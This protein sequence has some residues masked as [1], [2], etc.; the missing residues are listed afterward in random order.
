MDV[1]KINKAVFLM[2]LKIVLERICAHKNY[3]TE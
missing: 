2:E 3:N 1:A